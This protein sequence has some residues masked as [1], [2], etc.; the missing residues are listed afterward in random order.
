MKR[1]Y[2]QFAILGVLVVPVITF[3][4]TLKTAV[5][6]VVVVSQTVTPLL[7]SAALAWF[8]WS[9]I[10]FIRNSDNPEERKKGKN[11]MIWGI[12]ALFVMVAYL[13]LTSVFTN[14]LFGTSPFLPQLCS[15]SN[16]NC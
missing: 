16:N 13:G 4:Q 12:I 5:G 7:F 3:A 14:S 8:I 2:K 11:R 1:F 10:E 9:V 15:P 6:K